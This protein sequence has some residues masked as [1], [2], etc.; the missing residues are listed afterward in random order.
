MLLVLRRCIGRQCC[1][2]LDLSFGKR[3][4]VQVNQT[5]HEDGGVVLILFG[6]KL[7]DADDFL[8][9]FCETLFGEDSLDLSR[10]YDCWFSRRDLV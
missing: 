5:F 3:D 1:E 7:R 10:F 9:S 4:I 6:D 2:M 8:G